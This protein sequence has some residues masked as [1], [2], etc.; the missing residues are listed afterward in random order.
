MRFTETHLPGLYVVE[1][2]V[3]QDERG[4]FFEFF[5]ADRFADAGLQGAFVQGNQS[6][7]QGR[8]LRGLHYQYPRSQGKLVR[9]L[10][11]EI[12]DVALDLR[13]GSPTF[14][15]WFGM[16]LSHHERKS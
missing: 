2:K 3:F 14:G 9:V 1:P 7:S 11:G 6:R 16:L 8:V 12:Y 13:R 5:R 15:Q 10:Q 4:H